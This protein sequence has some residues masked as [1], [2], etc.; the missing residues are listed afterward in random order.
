M[1]KRDTSKLAEYVA[2]PDV[3][4]D[5]VTAKKTLAILSFGRIKK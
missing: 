5:E 3:D 1:K 2:I 4:M